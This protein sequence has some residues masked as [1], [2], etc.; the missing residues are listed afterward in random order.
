MKQNQMAEAN[1]LGSKNEQASASEQNPVIVGLIQG[2]D[3]GSTEANL[4]FTVGEIRRLAEQGAQIICTQ[5]LF[6]TA[7]FC[8]NK[9]PNI[10]IEQSPFPERLQSY[11]LNWQRNS[12]LFSL[13]L[14]LKSV[15]QHFI[16]IQLLLLIVMDG[17]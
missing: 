10:L 1:S 12:E 17:F 6:N 8:R 13:L 7:Y 15:L 11:Y 4:A 16:I 2:K 5:E 9:L 3:F 14:I